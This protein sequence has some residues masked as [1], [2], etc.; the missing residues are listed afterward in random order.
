M[1]RK[2][3]PETENRLLILYA[4]RC[5]GPMTDTQLLQLMVE[6][7]L[8][9][10]FTLQLSLPDLQEQGQVRPRVHPCGTLL[11]LTQ[12]GVFTLESFEARI[13][14]S[15]RK[16]IASGAQAY[17]QRFLQE[18]L[19]PAEAFRLPEGK[20][21]IR[22]RLLEKDASLL[23]VLLCTDPANAP[24]CLQQRWHA[25]A[26][27]V[28]SAVMEA[29]TGGFSLSEVFPEV[30]REALQ[31]ISDDEWLLSLSDDPEHPAITLMLPLPLEAMARCA[32]VRWPQVCAGLHADI[33]S[34]LQRAEIKG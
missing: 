10:Y 7:D 31:K 25:C 11:E 15:R 14:S 32:S 9:N 27:E 29:L 22:L 17:Q 34:M 18:Q 13:P 19:A 30:S 4:L 8:M 3:I 33:L 28:Y 16:L 6:L 20:V 21:C 2:H 24:S 23:D 12:E 1:E 5:L 26:Q